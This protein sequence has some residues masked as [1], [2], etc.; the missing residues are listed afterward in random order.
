MHILLCSRPL[1]CSVLHCC[2]EHSF[3]CNILLCFLFEHLL[4]NCRFHIVL[5][6][7]PTTYVFMLYFCVCLLC[8]VRSACSKLLPFLR[9]GH[10]CFSFRLLFLTIV[11]VVFYHCYFPLHFVGRTLSSWCSSFACSVI[12]KTR[13]HPHPPPHTRLL[14]L[15][16]RHFSQQIRCLT[17]CYMHFVG[18]LN[19]YGFDPTLFVD[20]FL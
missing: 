2:H 15:C 5:R 9:A 18:C 7:L 8:L 16:S 12:K 10:G 19:S 20:W 3:F 6:F 13:I 11:L 17:C 4:I 1:P 14:P